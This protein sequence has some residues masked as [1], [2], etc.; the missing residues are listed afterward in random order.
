MT[1]H[2]HH[3]DHTHDLVALG[4]ALLGFSAVGLL[5]VLLSTL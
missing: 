4:W 5:L 3:H 2:P 1:R